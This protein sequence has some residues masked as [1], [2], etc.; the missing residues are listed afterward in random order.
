M[1][2]YALI[3]FFTMASNMKIKERWLDKLLCSD[4]D[5]LLEREGATADGIAIIDELNSAYQRTGLTE[6]I[7]STIVSESRRIHAISGSPIRILEI[8][9]RDGGFLCEISKVAKPERIPLDLHGVEFRA[10]LT[11]LASER[12]S[13]EGLPIHTHYDAS[14]TLDSF[15]SRDFDIVYSV[16]VIHHQSQD[17]LN[18]LLSA[19]FR[20]SRNAVYHLDLTRSFSALALIWSFYTMFRYRASRQDAVL[21]CRRAY[22]PN[23][24][25]ALMNDL[26]VGRGAIIKRIF[27]MYWSLYQSYEGDAA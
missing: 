15:A 27:P 17:E 26:H 5:E 24:I 25:V 18:Q 20:V 7:V 3:A 8:G 19:S 4:A 21:S 14:R 1:I 13:L 9:M 6:R 22:R 16:F 10:D 11:T 2:D 23:E 12:V